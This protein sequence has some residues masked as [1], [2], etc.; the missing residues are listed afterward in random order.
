MPLLVALPHRRSSFAKPSAELVPFI[1]RIGESILLLALRALHRLLVPER[2]A[3]C[4]FAVDD[5]G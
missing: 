1:V 3:D 4:G 5:F 2:V